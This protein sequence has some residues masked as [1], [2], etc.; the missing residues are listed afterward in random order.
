MIE[1]KLHYATLVENRLKFQWDS[2]HKSPLFAVNSR[3][4][5]LGRKREFAVRLYSFRAVIW[6]RRILDIESGLGDFSTRMRE[7]ERK[8]ER[9][10]EREIEREGER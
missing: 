8:R 1:C 5:P 7:R 3:F 2:A 4:R 6:V 9:E 10:R